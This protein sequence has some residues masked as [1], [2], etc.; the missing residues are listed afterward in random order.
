[1]SDPT[2]SRTAAQPD[3]VELR[4]ASL[5]IALLATLTLA[6]AAVV[7]DLGQ[8]ATIAAALVGV[9]LTLAMTRGASA[10][11]PLLAGII[12]ATAIAQVVPG[13][14]YLPAEQDGMIELAMI[15]VLAVAGVV[16]LLPGLGGSPAVVWWGV[17][18]AFAA[19]AS[20]AI[21]LSV[22][23]ID[24]VDFVQD[25]ARHV[26][27]D[28]IYDRTWI[29]S[30]IDDGAVHPGFPYFPVT[31]VLLWP[32]ALLGD[33]RYGLLVLLLISAWVVGRQPHHGPQ[34]GIL[35]LCFPGTLL[36]LQSSWTEPLVAGLLLPAVVLL[37]RTGRAGWVG[38]ALFA[39]ALACKQHVLLLVPLLLAWPAVS[40][41]RRLAGVA[42][43][44]LLLAPWLVVDASAFVRATLE[45]QLDS[46]K[47][48]D[49]I[50]LWTSLDR[51]GVAPPYVLMSLLVVAT[52]VA[53]AVYLRRTQA[54]TE[55]FAYAC[56]LMLLV[57]NLVNKQGF[58]NQYWLVGALILLGL[59][60]HRSS[61]EP[62]VAR[63]GTREERLPVPAARPLGDRGE[64]AE[65]DQGAQRAAR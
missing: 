63:A 38:V 62:G 36:M 59:A 48:P 20:T 33:A 18:T 14:T 5:L 9:L 8:T 15:S 60:S 53:L 51:M 11:P 34:L 54:D 41:S 46:P 64:D 65:T 57:A 4:T 39:G 12:V 43:A 29:S 42:G 3:A 22:P 35:L 1:M 6:F 27:T 56:A 2:S 47:R 30:G 40:R 16:L 7:Y 10:S 26:F 32:F 50:S 52:A 58:Y 44:G 55:K 61:G 45:D 13:W 17:A 24:V 28:G 31:A 49:S 19:V 23:D 37:P 25:G 21:A